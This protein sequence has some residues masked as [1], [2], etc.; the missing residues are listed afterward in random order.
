MYMQLW[1]VM[2]TETKTLNLAVVFVVVVVVLQGN[3]V[4]KLVAVLRVLKLNW[5]CFYKAF[6][7]V[8]LIKTTT[9]KLKNELG[10]PH[11]FII[12]L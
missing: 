8:F 3:R 2:I 5:P 11:F 6:E 9:L 4:L 12:E 10:D 7:T 1:S